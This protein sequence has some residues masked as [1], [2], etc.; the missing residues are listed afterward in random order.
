MQDKTWH[1]NS[2]C[3]KLCSDVSFLEILNMSTI[4]V[5]M[6]NVSLYKLTYFTVNPCFLENVIVDDY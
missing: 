1:S 4:L 5:G 3:V 2:Y 6:Y